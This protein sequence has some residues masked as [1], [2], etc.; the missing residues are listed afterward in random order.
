MDHLRIHAGI[1]ELY[2][3]CDGSGI[4]FCRPGALRARNHQWRDGRAGRVSCRGLV[5]QDLLGA[6]KY[7]CA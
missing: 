1:Q 4:S 2:Q 5:R 3:F 7:H 6:T